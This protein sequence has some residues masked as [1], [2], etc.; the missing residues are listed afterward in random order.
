MTRVRDKFAALGPQRY[1]FTR[2]QGHISCKGWDIEITVFSVATENAIAPPG[3]SSGSI[4][5]YYK[6]MPEKSG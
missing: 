2:E 6:I 1:T 4:Y 5:V 3:K